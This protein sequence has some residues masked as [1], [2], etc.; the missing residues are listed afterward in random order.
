M[1]VD[2]LLD[3]RE[4]CK[5]LPPAVTGTPHA[6]NTNGVLGDEHSVGVNQTVGLGVL[7][8][9]FNDLKGTQKN[10]NTEERKTIG[11]KKEKKKKKQRM[12]E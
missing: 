5:L 8:D 1:V 3:P 4:L 10:G 11:E 6:I 2:R 7:A 9:F 12:N